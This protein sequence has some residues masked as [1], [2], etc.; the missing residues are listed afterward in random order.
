M[1]DQIIDA[2]M[3]CARHAAACRGHT[4]VGR[5]KLGLGLRAGAPM[6]WNQ[7]VMVDT[8]VST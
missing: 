3:A 8:E 6:G 4:L 2:V 7:G 1:S 5:E